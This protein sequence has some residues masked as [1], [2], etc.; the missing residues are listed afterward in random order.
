M[1][2]SLAA[3]VRQ[4]L[5][6]LTRSYEDEIVEAVASDGLDKVTRTLDRDM[7]LVGGHRH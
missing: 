7:L 3:S 6:G 1:P 4:A 5:A 2:L